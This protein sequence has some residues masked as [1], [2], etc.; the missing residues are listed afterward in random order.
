MSPEISSS[1]ENKEY[2]ASVISSI[3]GKPP[4]HNSRKPTSNPFT[5]ELHR[6][7]WAELEAFYFFQ[8]KH[9]ASPQC[10]Q[11]GR[12]LRKT[13]IKSIWEQGVDKIEPRW[14]HLWSDVHKLPPPF[15]VFSISRKLPSNVA[16]LFAATRPQRRCRSNIV[17]CVLGAAWGNLDQ[18]QTNLSTRTI[19]NTK[20]GHTTIK[21]GGTRI[22]LKDSIFLFQNVAFQV[23]FRCHL[24][25]ISSLTQSSLMSSLSGKCT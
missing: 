18:H 22:L 21:T 5:W 19:L 12:S 2:L 25:S 23:F 8:I 15:F 17:H 1:R 13:C 10:K 11:S 3:S 6:Q 16:M 7:D 9:F 24:E 4:L 14:Q 20:L